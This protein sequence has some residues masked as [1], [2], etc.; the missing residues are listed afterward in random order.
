MTARHFTAITSTAAAALVA[1]PTAWADRPRG[2]IVDCSKVSGIG[3][4]VDDFTDPQSLVVG[5]LAIRG[6]GRM[7]V[8]SVG[9]REKLLVFVKGG[10]RVTLE[11]PGETRRDAGLIVPDHLPHGGLGHRYTRRV[12]TFTACRQGEYEAVFPSS[13]RDMTTWPVSGWVGMLL[14]G[15]P[16]CVPLLVWVDDEPTPRRTVIRFGVLRCR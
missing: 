2:V 9:G 16:R 10:H 5:P 15:S 13:A 12:A 7:L 4:G 11:L 3:R 8:Y 14:A 1:A 6:A